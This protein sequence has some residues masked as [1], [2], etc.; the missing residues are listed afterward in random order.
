MANQNAETLR[1]LIHAFI[2]RFGL[3]DQTRTPCG[4][5]LAVSDAHALMELLQAPGIE[6]GELARRLGLS[7]SAVSRLMLR[8][9]KKKLLRRA[10]NGED[11]RAH[12]VR[13]TAKGGRMAARINRE[14]LARF[15]A[16]LSRLPDGKSAL[17][18][19]CLP[20]L[21]QAVPDQVQA[22]RQEGASDE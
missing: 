18:L 1:S 7:K 8:L 6:Q 15:G 5:P 13:L 17:L 20:H 3:L 14:S 11:R 19:E 22:G 9:E 12:N 10:K 2:R 21:V 4:L 16:I